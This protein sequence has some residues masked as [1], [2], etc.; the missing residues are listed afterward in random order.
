MQK[1]SD[2]DEKKQIAHLSWSPKEKGQTTIV[3]HYK[4][5]SISTT[6]NNSFNLLLKCFTKKNSF[7]DEGNL[8]QILLALYLSSFA[9]ICRNKIQMQIFSHYCIT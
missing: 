7:R 6:C 9:V 1:H 2:S 8:S 5:L 4:I 3:I